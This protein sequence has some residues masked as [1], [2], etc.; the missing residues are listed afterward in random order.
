MKSVD[1]Q[2]IFDAITSVLLQLSKNWTSV[3]SVCFDGASTMSGGIGGVQA[4][5]IKGSPTR[6]AILEKIISA[7]LSTTRRACRAEAVTSVKNHYASI[8]TTIEE[9][10]EK[11]NIP[12]M[13]AKGTELLAQMKSFEFIFGL[14]MMQ[15]ILQMILKISKLLQSNNLELLTAVDV[16]NSLKSSLVSMRNNSNSF[17]D[18]Y[19]N[20]LDMCEEFNRKSL[21]IINSI[22]NIVKLNTGENV[23]YKCLK[24]QFGVCEDYLC[25]EIILLQNMNDIPNGGTSVKTT[26]EWL[27]WLQDSNKSEIFSNFSKALQLFVTICYLLQVA[28]VNAAFQK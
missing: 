19:Q 23:S 1:A 20:C 21:Q 2:S 22:G 15:P 4:N 11:S 7:S 10:C 25:T 6:H 8:L 26:H 3:I 18:I 5:F 17:E 24:E 13:R 16:L 27:D 14:V 28:V 12:E 9:I